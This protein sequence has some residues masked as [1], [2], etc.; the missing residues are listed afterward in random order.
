MWNIGRLSRVVRLGALAMLMGGMAGG[1]MAQTVELV[2]RVDPSQISDTALTTAVPA[3]DPGSFA[4]HQSLGADGRYVVFTSSAP[5]LV[6]GQRDM[7]K[8]VDDPGRDVFLK[9]LATG[10]VTLVSHSMSGPAVTGN[11]R[12]EEA[13]ISADGRYV[14]FLSSATDLVPGQTA[15]HRFDRDVLLFDRTTGAITLELSTREADTFFG[16]LAISADGRYIAFVSDARDLVPGQQGSSGWNVFLYDRMEKKTRLVSHVSSSSITAGDGRSRRPRISADGRF[17]VFFSNSSDLVPGQL[18]TDN[19]FFYDRASEAITLIGPG[20]EPE[21]SADGQH[22]VFGAG[23]IALQLYSRET[24][25]TTLVSDAAATESYGNANTPF[26]ISADGRFVAYVHR[27]PRDFGNYDETLVI[28]DR[29]SRTSTTPSRPAAAHPR[30]IDLPRISADGRFVAFTSTDPDV[31]AGQVG[32]AQNVFLF[33][34]TSGKTELVS[35]LRTS[36]PT[37]GNHLSTLPAISADGSRVVFASRATNLLEGV[38]DLN[39]NWD[40]FAYAVASKSNDLITSRAATMPSVSAA[41]G[42]VASALSADGRFV[43]FESDSPYLI[44]GQIDSNNTTD[45]FLHDRATRATI[46]VSRTRASAVTAANGQS[47]QPAVSGDGRYVVFVSNAPNIA[48]G[49]N[50]PEGGYDVFLFDRIAGT[51]TFVARTR[52]SAGPET[53]SWELRQ[54]IS[55]DGRWVAFTSL[56]ADVIPG[57][58]EGNPDGFPTADI[59]LWDRITGS[60]TLV[61][62]ST[63]GATITAS[64]ESVL[65]TLGAD[66]RSVLFRSFATDLIPGQTRKTLRSGLFLFDRVSGTTTLVSHARDSLTTPASGADASISAEGRFV[67]FVSDGDL[68]P[69]VSEDGTTGVYLYDRTLGTNRRI[70]H[71]FSLHPRISADGRYVTFAST[72]PL[73]PDLNTYGSSQIYLYDRIANSLSLVTRSRPTGNAALGDSQDPAISADGRYVTFASEAVDLIPGLVP[74]PGRE[75][76]DIYLFDRVAGTMT[77]A[78]RWRGSAVAAMGR[79]EA[80]RMSANGRQVAFTSSADLVQGDLNSRSDAYLFSL[81]PPPPTGPTPLPACTLLD[82]RRRANRPIL[83]SNV[84]R[85]VPVRG[86]CGVPA[87]AKQVLVKVTVFNPSGKGNLRFYP[88]AVIGAPSGILRFERGATRAESFTL[89]LSTNGTLTILPFVAGKGTVHVAV[90]VNGYSQ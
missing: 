78:S 23:T 80:P 87:T 90:E 20:Q 6:P 28:Y 58:Q 69:N 13:V 64:S 32:T 73:L 1:L 38:K 84:Q 86:A 2:S 66:G 37:S 67:V 41:S 35:S 51:T 22:V 77:L 25:T 15:V 12:S 54:R 11:A 59:F 72:T 60:T 48:P 26:S 56:A 18:R 27:D 42:S 4:T 79:S 31:I 50:D 17:V 57:Q 53:S 36:A 10:A 29:V 75:D 3:E 89:P 85:T 76:D 33:D 49:G 44:S 39:E 52:Q 16:D 5:N 21:I 81:D 55:Q 43:A 65:E 68:D 14:A 46:L 9:D 24:N 88:A 34:R 71:G 40:L 7:N 70:G 47:V 61:S 82:T 74:S 45:V 83:S 8:S 62:R 19:V 63:L 30:N